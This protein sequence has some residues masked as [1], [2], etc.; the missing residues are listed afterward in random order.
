MA[1]TYVKILPGHG[2]GCDGRGQC[3]CWP[4]PPPSDKATYR[5]LLD[6]LVATS[7]LNDYRAPLFLQL[8]GFQQ[9]QASGLQRRRAH[10]AR[11]SSIPGR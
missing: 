8:E 1:Q 5:F 9:V 11:R 4:S 2:A 7:A 3:P 6:G 10:R